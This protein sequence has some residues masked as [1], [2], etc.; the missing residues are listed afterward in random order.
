[1]GNLKSRL[2]EPFKVI[3]VFPNGAMEIE[4]IKNGTRF[5]VNRQRLKAYL[6]N[7]AQAQVYLVVDSLEFTT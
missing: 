6:E 4:N 7:V 3:Q 1:M 5:K 2:V